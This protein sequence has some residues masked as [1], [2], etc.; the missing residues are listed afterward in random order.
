MKTDLH[1][2]IDLETLS[3]QSNGVVLSIGA[4]FFTKDKIGNKFYA[5]LDYY[6]QEHIKNRNVLQSNVDWWEAQ[7]KKGNIRPGNTSSNNLETLRHFNRFLIIA[8]QSLKPDPE[9]PLF[10]KTI[11]NIKV[12]SNGASFDIPM[13]ESLFIDYGLSVPWNFWNIRDVR[14]ITD[15]YPK[16]RE[17]S[18]E[19]DHNALNDAVN[20][21][22]WVQNFILTT[23][24]EEV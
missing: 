5:E 6:S 20:Q 8:D 11:D 21:A 23:Q 15:L 13:V 17:N 24:L 14:T 16:C 2:M 22:E 1:L 4:C 10:S 3:T 12:W 18:K 9:M 19:N 7:E